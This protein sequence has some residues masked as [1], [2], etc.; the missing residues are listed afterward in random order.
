M[1]PG[2]IWEAVQPRLVFGEN[3]RQTLQYAETGNVDVAIVAL[4]LS[5]PAAAGETPAGGR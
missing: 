5:V 1:R 2:G 3:V 4:S